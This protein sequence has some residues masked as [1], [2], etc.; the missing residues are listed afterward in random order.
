MV[1]WLF[2]VASYLPVFGFQSH[3]QLCG[4]YWKALSVLSV[5]PLT[6]YCSN[7]KPKVYR[8]MMPIQTEIW[9]P[10]KHVVLVSLTVFIGLN[11]FLKTNVNRPPS[12]NT[13][14]NKDKRRTKMGNRGKL[15][16]AGEN[17]QKCF[18]QTGHWTRG[19]GPK[20]KW[21]KNHLLDWMMLPSVSLVDLIV[22]AELS[23][24][25]ELPEIKR[26]QNLG[27]ILV[28]KSVSLCLFELQL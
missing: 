15:W 22:P 19:S 24:H 14:M 17:R 1:Q 28:T 27:S 7:R 2:I 3:H 21:N 9:R 18:C 16:Q 11:S 26:G 13:R 6:F 23:P 10:D 20:Q 4:C 8:I 25:T 12:N 5:C